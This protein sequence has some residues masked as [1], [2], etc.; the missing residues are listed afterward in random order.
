MQQ[1]PPLQQSDDDEVAVAEPTNATATM[2]IKR[3]F[4]EFSC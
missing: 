1:A 3:Y 4:M 2:I